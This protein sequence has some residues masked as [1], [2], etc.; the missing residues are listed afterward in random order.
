MSEKIYD[1]ILGEVETEN[2]FKD[3]LSNW[4]L[5]TDQPVDVVI[6]F[7]EKQKT[8]PNLIKQFLEMLKKDDEKIRRKIA[9][10]MI[11]LCNEDWN[12]DNRITEDVFANSIKLTGITI[13]ARRNRSELFYD[14][15]NIFA[16]HTITVFTDFDG[17]ISE[18]SLAG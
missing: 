16:G 7:G 3:W 9:D 12:P 11:T 14:D 1:S 13:S 10:E 17:N 15:A 5:R 6:R 18:P 4:N 2:N 8:L